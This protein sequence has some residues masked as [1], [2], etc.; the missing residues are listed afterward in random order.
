MVW[1]D[2]EN[3]AS[4]TRYP[5]RTA[6]SESQYRLSYPGPLCRL[7]TNY[8]TCIQSTLSYTSSSTARDHRA[9]NNGLWP[10]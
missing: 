6:R 7:S 2:A 1:T 5:D 9:V 8:V 3:L 4:A 10:R